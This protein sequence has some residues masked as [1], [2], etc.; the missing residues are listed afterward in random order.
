[1]HFLTNCL[2]CY[3]IIDDY[4]GYGTTLEDDSSTVAFVTEFSVQL[5]SITRSEDYIPTEE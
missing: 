4:Y 2:H 3:V 5:T 1:M